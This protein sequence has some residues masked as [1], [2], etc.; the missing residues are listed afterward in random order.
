M[1]AA[2]LTP[3]SR[4][5]HARIAFDERRGVAQQR[6]ERNRL[7]AQ[8]PRTREHQH[9]LHDPV[10]RVEARDDVEQN[11][12]IALFRRHARRDDL[13]RAPDPRNRVL[14]FVRDDR[15]HLA[16][17]RERLLFGEPLLERDAVA[18][19]VEDARE[20]ALAIAHH[21]ADRQMNGKA[22]AVLLEAGHFAADADDLLLAG[23]EIV[24]QVAVVLLAIGTWHQHVDVATD[25]FADR[26]AEQPLG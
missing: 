24:T 9:V 8:R 12:A 15:R 4:F 16:E 25:D 26:V 21:L 18:Q 3:I 20:A 10:Q 17:L 5:E 23:R 1:S 6:A 2:P 14:H 11:R 13:Q 19:I 22:R 7:L